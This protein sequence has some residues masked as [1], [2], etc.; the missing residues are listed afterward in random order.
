MIAGD[1][2]VS[3]ACGTDVVESLYENIQQN[4]GEALMNKSECIALKARI[5]HELHNLDLLELHFY[6][7]RIRLSLMQTFKQQI[8]LILQN[9]KQKRI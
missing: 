2:E 5:R 9:I 1:I 7:L 6:A 8:P 4:G 3:I